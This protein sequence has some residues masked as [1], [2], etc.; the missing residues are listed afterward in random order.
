MENSSKAGEPIVGATVPLR[1]FRA[2]R[3]SLQ[4][5]TLFGPIGPWGSEGAT[6]AQKIEKP[7]SRGGFSDL[8]VGKQQSTPIW[9]RTRNLRFRRPMLY[10]IELWVLV[11]EMLAQ[12]F[13]AFSA[14]RTKSITS[15]SMPIKS[16][17]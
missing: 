14:I 9:I 10:P 2:S 8:F 15:F 4:P 16:N 1:T 11:Q 7:Q 13:A 17:R 3:R 5:I 6:K 12:S